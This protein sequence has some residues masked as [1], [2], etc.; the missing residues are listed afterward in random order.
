MVHIR[1]M[2]RD[3]SFNKPF[4]K[5]AG[6]TILPRPSRPGKDTGKESPKTSPPVLDQKP[7][8]DDEILFRKA[9]EGVRPLSRDTVEPE[10]A[11][12]RALVQRVKAERA[13]RDKEALEALKNLV[14]GTATFDITCTGEYIEGCVASLDPAVMKRLKKGDF[15][16]QDH[17]DL[18]GMVR[19]QA[20]ELLG[21]FIQNSHAMGYRCLLVIHGRGLKSESGPVLKEAV[22]RWLTTG[23]LSRL[24]LAF[25]SARACDGGTGAL[26]V[27][28]KRRPLRSRWKK[29]F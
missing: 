5:L 16:V 12:S 10:P 18:H 20:R 17:L 28:L 22:V 4:A 19:E 1:T 6:L 25:C 24:V 23:S 14:K 26:Y 7:S 27:L 9:M 2:G 3:S 15:A 11:D 13:R 8:E 29:T 21:T